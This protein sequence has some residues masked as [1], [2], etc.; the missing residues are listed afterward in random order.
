MK[1]LDIVIIG[2]GPAGLILAKNLCKDFHLLVIEKEKSFTYKTWLTKKSFLKENDLEKYMTMEFEKYFLATS[3]SKE[4]IFVMNDYCSVDEKGICES[5]IQEIGENIH[6]NEEFIEYEKKKDCIEVKT[7]KNVYKCKLIIDC[8]GINSKIAQKNNLYRN[9]LFHNIY[10][11]IYN[12]SMTTEDINMFS[13]YLKNNPNCFFE[14]V[15]ISKKQCVAYTFQISNSP[16]KNKDLKNCHK[17][18]IQSFAKI[19]NVKLKD[20]I[21]KIEGSIPLRTMKTNALDHILFFGDSSNVVPP[22]SGVGFSYILKYNKKVTEHIKYCLINNKFSKKDLKYK[23]TKEEKLSFNCYMIIARIFQRLDINEID[24]LFISMHHLSPEIIDS[25]FIN[26]LT[27]E[28]FYTLLK[29]VFTKKIYRKIII[30]SLTFKNFFFYAK[31]FVK[32]VFY[33][34]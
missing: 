12:Y 20:K 2:A 8:S 30:K 7:S 11:E 23:L 3:K 21:Q 4:K 5:F 33:S 28:K 19:H 31:Q 26:T 14:A 9:E 34:L 18:N 27:K 17:F 10:G 6:Y 24:E 32:C 22:F 15:P 29:L 25:L 1:E 13:A 16:N